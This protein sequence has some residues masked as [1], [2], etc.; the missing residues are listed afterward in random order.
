MPFTLF[1]DWTKITSTVK[2]IVEGKTTVE[3]VSTQGMEEFK[4]GGNEK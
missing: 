4:R 3:K 2:D 1:D